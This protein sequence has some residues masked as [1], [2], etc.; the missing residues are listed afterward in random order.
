MGHPSDRTSNGG[1][2]GKQK[3]KWLTHIPRKQTEKKKK[4]THPK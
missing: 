3:T 4:H 1:R 2:G